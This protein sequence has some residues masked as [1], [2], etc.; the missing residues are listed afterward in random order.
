MASIGRHP[1]TPKMLRF[2]KGLFYPGEDAHSLLF[3]FFSALNYSPT[4][5]QRLLRGHVEQAKRLKP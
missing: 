4:V 5:A 2:P 1:E 3:E